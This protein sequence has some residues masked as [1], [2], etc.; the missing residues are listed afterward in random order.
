MKPKSGA[1]LGGDEERD[2]RDTDEEEDTERKKRISKS[3]RGMQAEVAK[4]GYDKF[5]QY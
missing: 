2:A 5:K 3:P 4:A 1:E